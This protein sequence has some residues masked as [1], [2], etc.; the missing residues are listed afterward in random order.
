[1]ANIAAVTNSDALAVVALTAPVV[2]NPVFKIE[3]AVIPSGSTVAGGLTTGQLFP[4]G[5]R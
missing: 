4:V 5:N 1:M 3:P 2:A